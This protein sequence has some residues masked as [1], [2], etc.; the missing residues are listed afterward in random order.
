MIPLGKHI[1]R[2]IYNQKMVVLINNCNISIADYDVILSFFFDYD[3]ETAKL[4]TGTP[5][6]T[7]REKAHL[8]L[9]NVLMNDIIKQKLAS[10]PSGSGVYMFKDSGESVIYVGKAKRLNQRVRSYF[11][12][13]ADHTGKILVMVKKITDLEVI[14]TDSESEALILEN[15]LIKKYRP[16]YNIL[17]RDDKSFPYI[18]ITNNEKPRIFPTRTVLRDGSRYFGPYDHVGKMKLMLETIRKAFQL[19]TCACSSRIID[20]SKGL[21]KWGKCFEDY[22]ENCSG[23]L[24]NNDYKVRTDQVTKLL[25][26]KTRDLIKDLK[27]EMSIL[28]D[29]LKFEKAALLRDGILALQK[30]SEKMKMVSDDGLDRDYFAL[31]V[32]WSENV[33]SGVLLQ[34]RD[35]KLLGKYHR[36]LKNIEGM[37]ET[38]LMQSFVEDYYT[39]ELSGLIPDEVCCSIELTDDDALFEY[40]W[41]R[42]KRK[43]P[44]TVPQRGEKAQLIQMA[45]SNARL[46]LN[47]WVLEKMKAEKGRVPHSIHAIKRDL[48][49]NRLPRRIECFD[50]SNFQGSFTV[51]SMVCFIDGQPRKGEYRRYHVKTVSGQDDYA[52]MREVIFRRYNRMKKEGIH[53]PDLIVIDGGKGQLSSA[54]SSLEK[55]GYGLE[56][57]VISLAKR[58]EEVFLP[59]S[60][61]PIMIPKTSSSL[62]LL[63][64]IRDEAHRFAIQFH[65]DLRSKKN[66]RSELREIPGIG[67]K[68]SEKLIRHFGSVAEILAQDYHSLESIAG[69]KTAN[70]ILAY[71]NSAR[72]EKKNPIQ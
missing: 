51:G 19:C 62:K 63:Q 49:L 15:N 35:G 43:V 59:G 55:I 28:S 72:Q 5:V 70:A 34:I 64:R 33:A 12:N 24:P 46:L 16:R 26:G 23:D 25:S 42:K 11:Q 3:W 18:C 20:Q 41:D 4:G 27:E 56:I 52:S 1:N 22:F 13:T 8:F 47:E 21:P 50:I 44:I 45:G 37:D 66:L 60:P 67:A 57:P 54:L 36:Y 71:F 30:Y 53:I 69:K 7:D 48:L 10:L 58:L 32:D 39:G 65:R 2:F 29:L 40:L 9:S 38:D 17:Y 14:V 68:T 61:N 31:E 6:T